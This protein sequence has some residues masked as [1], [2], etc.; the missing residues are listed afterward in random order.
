MRVCISGGRSRVFDDGSEI[1][2]SD[3]YAPGESFE[4]YEVFP[5]VLTFISSVASQLLA[6]WIYD[7]LKNSDDKAKITYRGHKI[8]L[9]DLD[10][11]VKELNKILQFETSNGKQKKKGKRGNR[12][13]NK[14]EYYDMAD[15]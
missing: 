2:L 3:D 14:P 7:K 9:E 8:S 4:L 15:F 10:D 1:D 6:S 5:I 13:N 11:F 12:Q